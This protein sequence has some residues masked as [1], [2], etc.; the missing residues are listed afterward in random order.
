MTVLYI[1]RYLWMVTKTNCVISSLISISW[2]IYKTEKTGK[3]IVKKR[4][5]PLLAN[6]FVFDLPS[7]VFPSPVNPGWHSHWKD[8]STLVQMPFEEQSWVCVVHSSIS[9]NKWKLHDIYHYGF[10]YFFFFRD[11][12]YSQMLDNMFFRFTLHMQT[13]ARSLT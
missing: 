13:E 6:Y 11:V 10:F 5:K 12:W 2:T 7:H 9:G 3:R 4:E 1:R 8:P